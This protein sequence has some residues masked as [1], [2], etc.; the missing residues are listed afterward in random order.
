MFDKKDWINKSIIYD[1][2]LGG[3]EYQ[4]KA[5]PKSYINVLD[6]ETPKELAEFLLKL[7]ADEEEY[8]SY[9]WWKVG[10]PSCGVSQFWLAPRVSE[11]L[12]GPL[13]REGEGGQG[14][15]Q[16]L[17]EAARV[18]PAGAVLPRPGELVVG[19]STLH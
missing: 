6:Y 14:D 2:V 7:A 16:T 9:F 18:S 15:V 11:T 4:Q 13:W 8:L 1:S 19:L 5:P 10:A 12:P 3:A 17:W